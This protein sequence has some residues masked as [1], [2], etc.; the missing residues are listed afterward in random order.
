M[1]KQGERDKIRKTQCLL[2]KLQIENIMKK[3]AGMILGAALLGGLVANSPAR[4]AEPSEALKLAQERVASRVSDMDL[5]RALSSIRRSQ[6]RL[7]VAR[8][9]RPRADRGAPPS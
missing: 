3:I 4:A 7:K 5:E 9:R 8:R 6:A 2:L 1:A